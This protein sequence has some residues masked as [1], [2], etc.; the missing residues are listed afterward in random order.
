MY[1]FHPSH[2]KGLAGFEN[3]CAYQ[4][5]L[6]NAEIDNFWPADVAGF[7]LSAAYQE[8]SG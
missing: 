2:Q 8:G 5:Q 6:Y 4:K 7:K 3:A 1:F